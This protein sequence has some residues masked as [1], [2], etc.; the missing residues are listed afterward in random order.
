MTSKIFLE[1]IKIY[2]YHGVLPEERKIGTFFTV[3]IEVHTD[4]WK[5]TE[6]DRLQDTI[7][8]ADL[9]DIVHHEMAIPS[10]LLEFVAGRILRS[11]HGKYPEITFV[12]V[13]LTK[14]NPPMR[15]EMKGASVEIE[16]A[17]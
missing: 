6:S 15:G 8:Y 5:A 14:Q 7:S 17:F 13:R 12:K 11:I 9:N 3:N 16:K 2:A 1:D 4:F 10:D